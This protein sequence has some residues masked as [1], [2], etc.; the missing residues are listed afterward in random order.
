MMYVIIAFYIA[1]DQTLITGFG[2][3]GNNL[4]VATRSY[5]SRSISVHCTARDAS[6]NM[7]IEWFFANGTKVKRSS[8]IG[9]L[10][11]SN[12]T[13][14]LQLGINRGALTYCEGGK[15]TCVVNTTSGRSEKRTFHLKIGS[16]LKA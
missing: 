3:Y 9:V 15:Y 13:T 10:K 12:G 16:E 11:Y 1:D 8:N 4:D 5:F 6:S 2:I 14:V 7:T